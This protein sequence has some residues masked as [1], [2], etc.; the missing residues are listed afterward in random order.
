MTKD[1]ESHRGPILDVGRYIPVLWMSLGIRGR[2]ARPRIGL[3]FCR[4]CNLNS[5]PSCRLLSS[6][7]TREGAGLW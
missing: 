2:L 7:V 6:Y 3:D 4:G 5:L 1:F